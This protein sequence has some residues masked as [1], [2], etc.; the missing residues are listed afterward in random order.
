MN[1][2]KSRFI[3]KM[4]AKVLAVCVA[5]TMPLNVS[6]DVR[7]DMAQ[8]FNS[9]GAEANYTQ[10]GAFHGQAGSLYSGGSLSVRNPVTNIN[11]V[12]IRLPTISA[13]CGGIDIFSG[14][15]SFVNKEQFIQ[16]T[17][18]LGNNAAGVAFDLALKALDPMIQDAIGGI[19]DLVNFV[20]S[21]NL[22]SC[23]SAKMLVGGAANMLGMSM[24][25][26]CQAA[27]TSSGRAEDASGA[28]WLC[29]SGREIVRAADEVRG[30]GGAQDTI[31][32]TGGNVTY[33]ALKKRFPSLSDAD[34]DWY[35][36][37]AGTAVYAP[38]SHVD[39]ET[40]KT[41]VQ[42]FAPTITRVEDILGGKAGG[43]SYSQNV[44]VDLLECRNGSK[45]LHENCTIGKNR[46]IPSLRYRIHQVMNGL[47][48]KI[49]NNNQTWT[50][51]QIQEISKYIN[52]TSI[53]VLRMAVS[54]V[55]FGTGYLAQPAVIDAITMD[56]AVAMLNN[57][58]RDLRQSLGYLNKI[59]E[60][61]ERKLD[62]VFDNL[63]EL[64]V[65]L[66]KARLE[67]L[68]R[69]NDEQNFMEKLKQ[70]NDQWGAAFPQ[71]EGSLI[72]AENNSIR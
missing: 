1:N 13:G 47:K 21:Q 27:S 49:Q 25:K 3:P 26:N 6:A 10:A 32:F 35:L 61:A 72:F 51:A 70:V 34:A 45:K 46:Q 23:E 60:D 31:S 11:P 2:P 64:R 65:N 19:R 4:P 62:Q 68:K 40:I 7:N 58:E 55:F 41:G 56:F 38:P 52:N 18:N 59:D 16:F 67:A 30:K 63:R 12:N 9:M 20:N 71:L 14:S 17:R 37:L 39:K 43:S 29:Q 44:Q 53:P 57:N 66:G 69:I 36:S 48:A 42:V 24:A 22:S 5:L 8:M 15:F 50:D 28:R 33:E 54:D